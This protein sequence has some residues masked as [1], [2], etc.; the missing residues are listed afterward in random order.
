MSEFNFNEQ[1]EKLLA[2]YNNRNAARVAKR[3][4]DICAALR[5]KDYRTVQ[6]K[7]GGSVKKGTFVSGLSDVDVLLFVNQTTLANHSPSKVI[8]HVEQVIK[9]RLPQ[10]DVK[11]GKLAVTVNYS[12]GMEIQLVPAL[13]T[14]SG[15]FR[16][17]EF[18]STKWSNIVIPDNFAERLTKIN[19]AMGS[20]VL[21]IIQLTK[22]LAD[23]SITNQ[24][25]KISGYHMESLAVNAFSDYNGPQDTRSMLIRFLRYSVRAVLT[26]IPDPT[27]QTT[28][29]DQS[30]GE[31]NSHARK[32]ASSH[33][34]QMR[35][36]VES[37]ETRA[38]FNILFCIGN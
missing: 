27:G 10:N 30:Q 23:C 32:V 12:N 7:L 8:K 16:I 28:F 25:H 26:P 29:A 19:V 24:D 18:G 34:G 1:C 36:N 17:A 33:F 31:A 21:P 4:D 15:G 20:R 6:T 35:S 11:A 3:L 22:A 5:R 2:R 9:K 37:C 13:R 14:K 38:Q